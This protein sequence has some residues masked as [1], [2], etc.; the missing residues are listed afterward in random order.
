MYRI[1]KQ[2]Q[3]EVKRVNPITEI[4]PASCDACIGCVGCVACTPESDALFALLLTG[5]IGY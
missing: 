4:V 1:C 2:H 5:T 3:M